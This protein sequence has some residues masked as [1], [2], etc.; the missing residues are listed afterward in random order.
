[1]RGWSIAVAS[2][3]EF[4]KLADTTGNPDWKTDA[5]FA[6]MAA[7]LRNQDT[8]DALIQEWTLQHTPQEAMHHLQASGVRAG[9]VLKAPEALADPQFL[10]RGFVDHTHHPEGGE[11]KHPGGVVQIVGA[12]DV[13]GAS[14]AAVC[15]TQRLGNRRTSRAFLIDRRDSPRRG[16]SSPGPGGQEIASKPL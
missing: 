16:C 8:L 5:R 12:V 13:A 6:S 14:G 9:A 15:G 1:M 3:E 10:A 4:G 2:D 7:R 11:F